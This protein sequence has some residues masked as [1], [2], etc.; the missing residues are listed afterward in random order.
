MNK[1]E[2]YIVALGAVFVITLLFSWPIMVLWNWLMP[3]I[4]GVVKISFWKALGLNVLCTMLFKHS[5][6]SKKD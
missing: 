5:S 2:A 3:D 1:I 6:S 4:F